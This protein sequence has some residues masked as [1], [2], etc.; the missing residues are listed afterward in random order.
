MESVLCDDGTNTLRSYFFARAYSSS[1]PSLPA[2]T[3]LSF[4]CR[5][6]VYELRKSYIHAIEGSGDE[7]G[8]D[9][10]QVSDFIVVALLLTDCNEYFG[11]VALVGRH[12]SIVGRSGSR[13]RA[14]A[15][16]SESERT[17]LVYEYF[18]Y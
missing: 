4:Y 18:N 8:A 10:R 1:F 5:D 9:G 7:R 15:V 12:N 13:S 17:S 16:T 6:A 14:R 2:T 11:H 3:D